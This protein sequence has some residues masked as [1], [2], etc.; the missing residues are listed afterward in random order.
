MTAD[1]LDALP[2]VATTTARGPAEIDALLAAGEP[3]RIEGAIAGW[4]V[5]AAGRDSPAALDA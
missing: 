5:L 3:V 1:P 4:P 2:P